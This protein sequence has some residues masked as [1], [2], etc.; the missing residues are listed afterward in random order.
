VNGTYWVVGRSAANLATTGSTQ[1]VQF[2][3]CEPYQIINTG[4]TLTF[5]ANPL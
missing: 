4:G 1:E 2:V 5:P 3:P